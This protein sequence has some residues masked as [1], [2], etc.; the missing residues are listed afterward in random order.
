MIS[1][2]FYLLAF[3]VGS[4]FGG[5]L[6]YVAACYVMN[7]NFDDELAAVEER[8]TR[9]SYADGYDAGVAAAKRTNYTLGTIPLDVKKLR[10][11]SSK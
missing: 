4:I 6:T 3:A 11:I 9:L 10:L 1:I 2:L 7:L 5:G 8:A